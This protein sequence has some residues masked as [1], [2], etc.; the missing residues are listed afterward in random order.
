MVLS[1]KK[2]TSLEDTGLTEITIYFETTEASNRI[3]QFN[4]LFLEVHIL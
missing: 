1:S 3:Y 4:L 2:S